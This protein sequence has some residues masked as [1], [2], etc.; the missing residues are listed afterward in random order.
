MEYVLI[1]NSAAAIGAVEG[2]RQIDREGCIT[3]ITDEV[4]HTYSRPL[5]SYFL[6][7][8]VPEDKMSYRP[9]SFYRDNDCRLLLN[10]R[11]VSFDA[12]ART[13]ALSDG[14]AVPYDKLLVATGSRPFVP[15]T[16]GAESVKNSFT[17]L[18]LDDAKAV[19]G[20]VTPD[21]RVL[22]VGAG[23]IGLKA[24]EGLH[25][26]CSAITV[27]DLS[28]RILPSIL[29]ETAS[30][31]VQRHIEDKGIRF[32]LGDSVAR[33][34][35]DTAHLKS[36][37]AIPFDLLITAVGVR[38]N[39]ELFRDAGGT[40][41]RG[42][43]T[44]SRQLTSLPDV[45]AAGDCCESYDITTGQNRVL[46]LLPSA[47][48]QGEC[49]GINMAGGDKEFGGAIPMNAI[50][51]FG[52]HMITAGSYDGEEYTEEKNGVYKKL[53]FKDGIMMGYILIGDIARAGIYT[54]MI[55]EQTPLEA[56]D[57]ELLL[58]RPQL[59]MFSKSAREGKLGGKKA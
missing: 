44:D 24:A 58:E 7:G 42:I 41:G 13:V 22:I 33:Y 53:V 20:A 46:A 18:S 39:T 32:V 29:D 35:G 59:L 4:Y 37:D 55:K 34:E 17:F 47:Y 6:H 31:L 10:K 38:P 14:T 19:G 50:G 54:S 11:A 40:V 23:L 12:K 30:A 1:G 49:A 3:V 2:I 26:K 48:M 36:G 21:S 8:K 56:V 9:E 5:I 28:P 16:E 45:Y 52:L 43:L 15:P 25:G 27:V 51:F 57:F